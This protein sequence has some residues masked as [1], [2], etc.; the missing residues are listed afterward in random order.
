[1]LAGTTVGVLRVSKRGSRVGWVVVGRKCFRE[2]GRLEESSW[3]ADLDFG[4]GLEVEWGFGS[5]R[6]GFD[7]FTDDVDCSVRDFWARARVPKSMFASS[8]C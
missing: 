3:G 1:M 5:G 2:T 8:S 7:F 4:L 6:G